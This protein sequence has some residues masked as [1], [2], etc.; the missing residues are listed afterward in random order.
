MDGVLTMVIERSILVQC[1][2]DWA[3]NHQNY[4]DYAIKMGLKSK[5]EDPSDYY[6]IFNTL[7]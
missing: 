1:N 4:N 7:D 3:C 5:A 2:N 6:R